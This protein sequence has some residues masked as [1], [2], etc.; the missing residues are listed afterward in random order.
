M[1]RSVFVGLSL[2]LL[3]G[4]SPPKPY[5]T[6][7]LKGEM[8]AFYSS[9]ANILPLYLNPF[10]FYEAKNRP[11]VEKHLKSLHDH[12]VQV[13]SLLAK[14]DEEHRVLSVSLE[15]SAA[16]ALKSYQRGNRGQT[17]YFMGEILD[18]CLS[19][20]T[21]RESEKDSPFNIARNV[22]MEAL[23]PFGR[24]KLLT[25]SR[26]FDEAMKE[27]EDLILKR[28][29]ILSDIIHFDPFLN[30]LVIGV[31]VKPDLNRVLKTLEQAN[32]RPVP[33]SVKADIKVWIKSIQDIKGNKSLK[34]GDLLAQAQRLMDAGKNLMEYPRDQ[35]GSIYYLEASR[36]L[37]DFINLKG[38]KAKDKATAY[39]L[40][41]KAEMVLGR[42]FLG[43]EARR[44]FA[45]TIDL[46]PKSNIA[47]QAFRLYEESVMFGYTGSSGLH[48]PEDEAERL[49]ALRKKAY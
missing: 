43:L 34:Q 41:G 12:S 36:R 42:P 18:T 2:L 35:S 4:F 44:Y 25:V 46:A 47:Q 5:Q 40:M 49:E 28:N 8:T 22:N 1:R 48:L 3:T 38:T 21:S 23:D 14:S 32:K 39:F 33:T 26:Q 6:Q 7:E 9:I 30:Y 10:R 13:K 37:K 45:T 24:A 15:E 29:L 17:S 16:L 19:C 27:Y 31:R 20:H 11:V